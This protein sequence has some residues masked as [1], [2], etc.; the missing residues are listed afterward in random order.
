MSSKAKGSVESK[1]KVKGKGN[2]RIVRRSAKYGD[3]HGED[4]YYN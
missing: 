4:A 3:H 1:G 2:R